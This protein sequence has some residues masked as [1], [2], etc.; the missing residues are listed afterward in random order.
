M[1]IEGRVVSKFRTETAE[2]ARVKVKGGLPKDTAALR[3]FDL[4]DSGELN[5]GDKVQIEITRKQ[6]VRSEQSGDVAGFGLA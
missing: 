3:Y 5:V 6:N 1:T 2:F 4:P